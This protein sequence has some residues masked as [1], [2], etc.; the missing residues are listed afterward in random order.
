MNSLCLSGGGS[1][2][3]WS[4][5]VL[6]RL[7]YEK[8]FSKIYGTSVG[9]MNAVLLG[10]AYIDKNPEII[11]E[12][13]TKR[14]KS[15]KNVYTKKYLNLFKFKAPFSF[16][17]LRHM[18]DEV[19]DFESIF[20]LDKEII[21][22]SVDIVTA[23][24]FYASTKKTSVDIFKKALIA[25]SSVPFF[26]NPVHIDSKILVDGGIKENAPLRRI[27]KDD[28]IKNVLLILSAPEQLN[29]ENFKL[30]SSDFNNI[31]NILSRV[32]SI[33]TSEIT[34]KDF[35]IINI[36]NNILKTM[37][38]EQ[39]LNN[40]WLK[41]KRI[42]NIDIIKPEH[43]IIGETLEFERKKLIAGFEA[44]IKAAEHYLKQA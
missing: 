5:G 20:K 36:I 33:M 3:C 31:Y 22:T 30:Y 38:P 12:I 18:I 4:A 10:Q 28:E 11:K 9:S 2:G 42:I 41:D 14:I 37:T 1:S 25:S 17:P 26:S 39:I 43:I 35:N 24:T 23:K 16:D 29:S 44:G 15:Y 40:E 34:I 6:Y 13:W 27:L 21:I 32:L 19:V 7:F 8:E